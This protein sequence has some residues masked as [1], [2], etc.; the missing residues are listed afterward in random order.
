M[1][2]Q[3]GLSFDEGLFG[4]FGYVTKGLDVMNK[5]VPGDVLEKAE[6]TEGLDRL[7]LPPAPP[8]S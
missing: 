2:G 7:V 6:I 5:I 3:A 1:G 8:P 4:V